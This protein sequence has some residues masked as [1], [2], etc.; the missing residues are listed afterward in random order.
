MRPDMPVDFGPLEREMARQLREGLR[1]TLQIAVDW[2]GERVFER[3]LGPGA[4]VES[5][6]VLWS[7]TKPFVAVALLQLVEEGK[8]ALDGRVAQHFPEFGRHGKERVT[9]AQT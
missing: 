6:Y 9:L 4:S 7:A 5:T 2:R 3:A 8:L 1:P